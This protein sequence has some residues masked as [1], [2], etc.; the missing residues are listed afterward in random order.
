MLAVAELATAVMLV[1]VASGAHGPKE[2]ATMQV[3]IL[4]ASN[5]LK[6]IM[7]VEIWEAL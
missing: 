7:E 5:R 2:Q 3:R 4:P 1:T 6:K